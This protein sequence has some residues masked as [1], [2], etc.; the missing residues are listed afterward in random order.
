MKFH[1]GLR[2]IPHLILTTTHKTL[3]QSML[4][5]VVW[6]Y[7]I[8]C[9]VY[10]QYLPIKP[11]KFFEYF[12]CFWKYFY[13]FVFLSFC[14]KCIFVLFFENFF[15]GIFA[16]SSWLSFSEKRLR[17]KMEITKFHTET[18]MTVLWLKASCER[19]CALEVF[20]ASNF[21]SI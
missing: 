16:R 17:Q 18:F 6:L 10:A 7:M 14:S 12:I 20:F 3:V 13:A 21:T 11:K 2:T 1:S 19:F 8:K 5:S 4:I 9:D 15:K